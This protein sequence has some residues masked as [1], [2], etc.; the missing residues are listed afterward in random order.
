MLVRMW[1]FTE[2]EGSYYP[3]GGTYDTSV[4]DMDTGNCSEPQ[5]FDRFE[6]LLDYANDRGEELQEVSSADEAYTLCSRQ[7]Y[8]VGA[9]QC[10]GGT[11]NMP[12]TLSAAITRPVSA[13]SIP[14]LGGGS[15]PNTPPPCPPV[16]PINEP[17]LDNQPI[18]TTR[19]DAARQLIALTRKNKI[20]PT[21]AY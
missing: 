4:L 3:E 17:I 20:V 18:V 8:T 14:Y 10:G 6:M 21:I 11:T 1:L 5:Q 15:R 19:L 9:L 13:C 12:G 16:T 2:R 7:R